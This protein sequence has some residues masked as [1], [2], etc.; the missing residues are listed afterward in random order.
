MCPVCQTTWACKEASVCWAG[1][2]ILRGSHMAGLGWC[3]LRRW[4]RTPGDCWSKGRYPSRSKPFETWPT[5]RQQV[6]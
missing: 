4:S 1:V 3:L 2:N 5:P 6:T